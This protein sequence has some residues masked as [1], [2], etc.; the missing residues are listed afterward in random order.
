MAQ[1]V[2]SLVGHRMQWEQVKKIV[3]SD[4][5]SGSFLFSGP[6]GIGKKK[7][8][9]SLAQYFLCT[10][11]EG[12]GHCGS[13]RR[14]E[15]GTHEGLLSIDNDGDILKIE[16]AAKVKEFLKLKSLTTGRFI[17]INDAH[18]MNIP[19]ANALLKTLEEPPEGV[20][21]ILVTSRL[22]GLLTTIKSR[23]RMIP[24]SI[25]NETELQQVS[26]QN[27]YSVT[28][29]SKSGQL[30]LVS[31]SQE[32]EFTT[33]V[34]VACSVLD[35]IAERR[36]E[37]LADSQK[38]TIKSKEMFLD[39]IAFLEIFVRDILLVQSGGTDIY[40]EQF[41][42]DIETW[43]QQDAAIWSDFFER[44]RMKKAD[45]FLSPDSALFVESLVI[46]S[47]RGVI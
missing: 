43:A 14:V 23:C 3:G 17:I 47:V 42:G 15:A 44:L 5:Q 19:T 40:F 31:K 7:L 28:N 32:K 29:F 24:F 2:S 20:Y 26:R 38:S 36:F 41:A 45:L 11:G 27:E 9:W 18:L 25:L 37:T 21:F 33:I 4:L 39:L 12:C 46:E 10:T 13:C 8:A 35:L 16:E 30:H 22:S 34:E 6:E 1:I